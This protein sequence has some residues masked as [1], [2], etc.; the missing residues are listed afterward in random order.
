LAV[1]VALLFDAVLRDRVPR[2]SFAVPSTP[3][4]EQLLKALGRELW[5][6]G[7]ELL[8]FAS[9]TN[10]DVGKNVGRM[11]LGLRNAADLMLENAWDEVLP[12]LEEASVAATEYFP[13]SSWQGL[14]DLFAY[15]QPVPEL[16]WSSAQLGLRRLADN[17]EAIYQILKQQDENP[18]FGDWVNEET[19]ESLQI[20]EQRLRKSQCLFMDGEFYMP[21]EPRRKG[22]TYQRWGGEEILE[23]AGTWTPQPPPGARERSKAMAEEYARQVNLLPEREEAYASAKKVGKEAVQILVEAEEEIV[24]SWNDDERSAILKRLLRKLHPDQNRGKE[25]ATSIAFDYVRKVRYL[26]DLRSRE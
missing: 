7:D 12:E 20:A 24:N 23:G 14:L 21:A 1:S 11:G 13:T 6:I 10:L 18:G 19:L 16:E 26:P 9:V 22:K 5:V 3:T 8:T 17:A 4:S 2:P 15:D 25:E